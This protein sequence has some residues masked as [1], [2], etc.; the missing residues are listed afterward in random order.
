MSFLVI[1]MLKSIVTKVAEP[2]GSGILRCAGS[3]PVTR[4]NLKRPVF[5]LVVLNW[6]TAAAGNPLAYVRS[7][8][9]RNLRFPRTRPLPRDQGDCP[10]IF[11]ATLCQIYKDQSEDWSLYIW[12]IAGTRG[13]R[14]L[15]PAQP[16]VRHLWFPHA[17][18]SLTGGYGLCP[19][20]SL[21]GA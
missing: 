8:C 20:F 6:C 9:G 1:V 19:I 4:T 15:T 7:T 12:S 16:A 3:T 2:L 14:S 13:I 10:E 18:P 17:R 11:L 5:G 21:C